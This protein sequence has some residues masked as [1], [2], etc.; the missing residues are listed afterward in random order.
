[1]STELLDAAEAIAENEEVMGMLA[2]IIKDNRGLREI[3]RQVQPEMRR[4]IYEGL[5]PHLTKRF[6]PLSYTLIKP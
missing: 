1:V 3:I 6:S 4:A 2:A 5:V